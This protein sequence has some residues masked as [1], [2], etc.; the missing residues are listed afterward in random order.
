MDMSRRV[1]ATGSGHRAFP[2]NAGATL[3]DAMFSLGV[4]AVIATMA[5][6]NVLGGADRSRG[7]AAARYLAG[8]IAIARAHAIARSANV[9]LRFREDADGVRFDMVADGN[10]NG[11]R[12]ADIDGG[13][14]RG[15]EAA[16][17]LSD[18][19][20]GVSIALTDESPGT[21]AVQ[22]GRTSLLSFSPAATATSGTIYIRGRDGTQWAVRVLGATARTRVLRLE[23]S[24]EWVPAS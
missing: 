24:G 21:A 9:A 22:I 7:L 11:V 23:S 16:V 13:I 14:D 1:S 8:R 18:M 10:G 12:T 2:R 19:F 15:V 17:S 6:P 3:I 4:I 20:P 5:V